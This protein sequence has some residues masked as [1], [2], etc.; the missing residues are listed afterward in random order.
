MD[1]KR[2]F[3]LCFTQKI[4]VMH[5]LQIASARLFILSDKTCSPVSIDLVLHDIYN[6]FPPREIRYLIALL[7]NLLEEK[8][9]LRN[10]AN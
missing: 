1:K 7:K 10:N 9:R 8:V 6:L 2:A 5:F 4:C 3:V